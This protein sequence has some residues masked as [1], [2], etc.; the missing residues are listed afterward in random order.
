MY[1][2]IQESR[3]RPFTLAPKKYPIFGYL[4]TVTITEA[5]EDPESKTKFTYHFQWSQSAIQ[6]WRCSTRHWI[7]F[8][9]NP[10]DTAGG[11]SPTPLLPLTGYYIDRTYKYS[12]YKIPLQDLYFMRE[13]FEAHRKD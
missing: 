11:C 3:I 1:K 6:I 7:L 4:I 9:E 2:G 13:L 5:I 8:L 12:I 10:K